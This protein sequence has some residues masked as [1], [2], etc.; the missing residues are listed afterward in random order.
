MFWVK[1]VEKRGDLLE[2]ALILPILTMLVFVTFDLSEKQIVRNAAAKAAREAAR[3]YA[4]Q[5]D[6]SLAISKAEETFQ[7]SS[8][9]LGTLGNIQ[10]QQTSDYLGTY[11]VASVQASF[12]TGVFDFAW[13][14]VGDSPPDS[15]TERK[16]YMIEPTTGQR[17]Y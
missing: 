4:Q 15:V 16:V 13:R 12:R 6:M 11:A 17:Q 10:I 7:A 8:Q 14:L 3:I 1:L 2:A 5:Q 9:G